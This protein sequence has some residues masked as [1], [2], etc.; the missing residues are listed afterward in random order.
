MELAT[1]IIIS[2]H[3]DLYRKNDTLSDLSSLNL[4]QKISMMHH[5]DYKRYI[6][7]NRCIT[8]MTNFTDH[9]FSVLN[10]ENISKGLLYAYYISGYS[11]DIFFW[12]ETNFDMKLVHY[13]NLI[14]SYLERTL[15]LENIDINEFEGTLDY[16]Y[17]LYNLWSSKTVLKKLED[18]SENFIDSVETYSIIKQMDAK[19][20]DLVEYSNQIKECINDMIQVDKY[21]AIKMILGH[22]SDFSLSPEITEYVWNLINETYSLDKFRTL[23]V[24]MS[25]LR[26]Q[27]IFSTD[28]QEKIFTIMLILMNF[29]KMYATHQLI[30]NK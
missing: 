25:K 16:Y 5:S 13:A 28:D 29:M 26:K 12:C 21:L 1:E 22:Y 23:S 24:I 9:H 18:I 27:L 4:V 19:S 30:L 15:S 17:S 3:S 7:T 8:A 11:S 14:V 2:K 10:I 20:L 6:D